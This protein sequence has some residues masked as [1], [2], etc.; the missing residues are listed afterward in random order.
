VETTESFFKA[1]NPKR[2]YLLY[3]GKY[4]G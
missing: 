3:S 2:G 1:V 4:Y